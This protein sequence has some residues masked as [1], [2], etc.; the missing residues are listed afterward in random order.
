[1][2][3]PQSRPLRLTRKFGYPS[4]RMRSRVPH[5]LTASAL[6]A[7]A[8]S[9]CGSTKANPAIL[10]APSAPQG[11]I[12]VPAPITTPKTGP[13]SKEPTIAKGKGPAPTKLVIKDLVKGTGAVLKVG[14]TATVN[15][16]GAAYSSAKVFDASWKTGAPASFP[17]V[18]G[19][20]IEGW[21]Q[22]LPGMRIG[23]RR[24]LIIPAALAY[25]KPGKP[26]LIT[27]NEP[28]T[29]IIDLLGAS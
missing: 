19:G 11:K 23:G 9:A 21:V 10:P 25:G 13:L 12:T 4:A 26:P 14:Q 18:T 27:P 2:T 5:L 22:G 28:L 8:L 20:L 17:L 7:L 3:H 16:V 1:V 24:E 15:Y 6:A 29:F